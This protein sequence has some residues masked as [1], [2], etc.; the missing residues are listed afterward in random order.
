M[1]RDNE[2]LRRKCC[3]TAWLPPRG[4]MSAL[5]ITRSC[6][7]FISAKLRSTAIKRASVE[8]KPRCCQADVVI[9]VRNRSLYVIECKRRVGSGN[10][11]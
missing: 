10:A 3:T 11:P 7:L 1:S 5:L 2:S 6:P 9:G 8:T 4:A